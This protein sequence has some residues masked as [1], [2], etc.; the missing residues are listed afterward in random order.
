M[1]QF[2]LSLAGLLAM[3]ALAVP[4]FAAHPGQ[5]DLGFLDKKFD[6]TPAIS[7]SLDDWLLQLG[8]EA[9]KDDP[10]LAALRGLKSL[11]VRVY[12]SAGDKLRQAGQEMAAELAHDGWQ[13][14]VRVR[15]GD[16]HVDV[17]I[18]P[19]GENI[20]G[21]TVLAAGDDGDAVFVNGYGKI[22]PRDLARLVDDAGSMGGLG[23]LDLA[24]ASDH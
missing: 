21:F 17:L 8:S 12:R 14:V 3:L 5:V 20:A 7:V 4:A 15:E 9:I 24:A 18:K 2:A 11:Q 16:E 22:S 23:N 19:D 13:T 6:A 10:E 1:K